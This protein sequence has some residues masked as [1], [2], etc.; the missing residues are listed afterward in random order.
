MLAGGILSIGNVEVII[1]VRVHVQTSLSSYGLT[2][3]ATLRGFGLHLGSAI[4]SRHPAAGNN[5]G[6]VFFDDIFE[7]SWSTRLRLSRPCPGDLVVQARILVIVPAGFN[8]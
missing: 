3:R 2:N 5:E 6:L 8:A 4:L 1:R 7:S